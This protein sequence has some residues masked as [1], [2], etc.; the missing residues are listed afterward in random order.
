MERNISSLDSKTNRMR[1]N[2]MKNKNKKCQIVFGF[3][4][5]GMI[6]FRC[7]IH[8]DNKTIYNRLPAECQPGVIKVIESL[9]KNENKTNKK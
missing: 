3:N 7:S 9:F 1:N 5:L 4:E 2:N 6:I 8:G